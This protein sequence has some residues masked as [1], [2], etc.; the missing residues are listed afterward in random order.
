MGEKK[1]MSMTELCEK[2]E[3][4]ENE[5]IVLMKEVKELYKAK[6]EIEKLKR[7]KEILSGTV[8]S[9]SKSNKALVEAIAILMEE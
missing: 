3:R 9:L 4:I 1:L 5:N 2:F 6:K 8:S 7:E